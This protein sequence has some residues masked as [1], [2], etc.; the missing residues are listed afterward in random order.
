MQDR[1]REDGLPVPGERYPRGQQNLT[2]FPVTAPVKDES[3]SYVRP[4]SAITPGVNVRNP[5]VL[6]I[7]KNSQY[8]QTFM[9]G[10]YYDYYVNEMTEIRGRQQQN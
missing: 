1:H 9:K 7:H 2:P 5:H 3:G 6:Q 10:N 8:P 4:P